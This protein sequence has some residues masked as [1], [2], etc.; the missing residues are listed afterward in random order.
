V[1]EIA[2]YVYAHIRDDIKMNHKEAGCESVDWI[3]LAPDDD[4][5]MFCKHDTE[6]SASIRSRKFLNQLD[7]S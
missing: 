4:R 6:P 3:H 7:D 2:S 5:I 1:K